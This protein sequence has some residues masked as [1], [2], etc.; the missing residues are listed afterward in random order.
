VKSFK[1]PW[2]DTAAPGVGELLVAVFSWVAAQERE[3]IVERVRAGLDRAKR[4]GTKSGKA[5][6]RPRL[7]LDPERARRAVAQAGSVRQAAQR[8]GVSVRS[9]RR[10]L[11]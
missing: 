11:A 2:L 10:R 5:I 3:R 4:R 9:L 8:L 1:E 6:G 7:V